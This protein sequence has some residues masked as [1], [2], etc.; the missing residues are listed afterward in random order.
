MKYE[1]YKSPLSDEVVATF[2]NKKDLF[3]Y[4]EKNGT[5]ADAVAVNGSIILGWDEL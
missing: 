1:V 5:H 2:G 4:A 3:A